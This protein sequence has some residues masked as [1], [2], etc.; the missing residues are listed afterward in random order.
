[1]HNSTLIDLHN[2][3]REE[4]GDIFLIKGMMDKPNIVF[5]YIP[6]DI[7]KVYRTEGIWPVRI[8][9]ETFTYYRKKVRPD[10]FKD[11]GG[12]VSE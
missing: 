8:G 10:I 6:A 11:V 12:L 5:T 9:L 7:E 3:L 4:Y 2:V 1:M